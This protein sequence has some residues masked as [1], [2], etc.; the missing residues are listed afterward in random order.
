[1]RR[2]LGYILYAISALLAVLGVLEI[3]A[4][5]NL[6]APGPGTFGEGYW[7]TGFT[8]LLVCAF[9]YWARRLTR[10]VDRSDDGIEMAPRQLASSAV[11]EI[12]ASTH[13]GNASGEQAPRRQP[14][15]CERIL[16][17]D[18][19]SAHDL[20]LMDGHEFERWLADQFTA[21]GWHVVNVGHGGGDQGADLLIEKNGRRV[22]VQAKRYDS[23]ISNSAVQQAYSAIP[24]YRAQEAWVVTN[25][26]FTP[27]AVQLASHTEIRLCDRSTLARWIRDQEH[28]GE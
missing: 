27:Q 10:R 14:A 4:V 5:L 1:M 26:S 20:G 24:V 28:F 9:A 8:W 22:V 23:S 3:L 2:L 11:T 18:I 16:R 19:V 17:A 21:S 6:I 7:V 13:S 12:S 25:G 15:R